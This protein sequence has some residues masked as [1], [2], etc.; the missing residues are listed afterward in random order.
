MIE[1]CKDPYQNS[2]QVL[3]A[4]SS[5]PWLTRSTRAE[6]WIKEIA[7][8]IVT[9]P[10]WAER[11]PNFFTD[12]L[13]TLQKEDIIGRSPLLSV[14]EA[15][16][17]IPAEQRGEHY[18]DNVHAVIGIIADRVTANSQITFANEEDQKLH[19]LHY[20]GDLHG[21][22][23]IAV[24]SKLGSPYHELAEVLLEK[25]PQKKTPE[26]LP[27]KKA[28]V[29][30]SNPK[31]P[32]KLKRL[33][34]PTSH[35]NLLK[36]PARKWPEPQKNYPSNTVPNISKKTQDFLQRFPRSFPELTHQAKMKKL[37]SFS[38][39]ASKLVDDASWYDIAAIA[40]R[41]KTHRFAADQFFKKAEP[42]LANSCREMCERKSEETL[43][44]KSAMAEVYTVMSNFYS[45]TPELHQQ[46]YDAYMAGFFDHDQVMLERLVISLAYSLADADF[47][48]V[49]DRMLNYL[50]DAEP[51]MPKFVAAGAIRGMPLGSSWEYVALDES[52][53]IATPNLLSQTS[54]EGG[55]FKALQN[56]QGDH[57]SIHPEYDI[58]GFRVDF[59]IQAKN[60]DRYVIEFDGMQFHY[61]NHL[62]ENGMLWE[63]EVREC[64]IDQVLGMP[65][66]RIPS[67]DWP[68]DLKERNEYLLN[69]L[70]KKAPTLFQE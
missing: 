16:G 4:Q 20:L 49:W 9:D 67:I 27:L 48:K 15:L 13:S 3:G 66:I 32:K 19:A 46:M 10:S 61:I 56:I 18:A 52:V 47:K 55:V 14:L 37:A 5:E 33:T 31:Q 6:T 38:H 22:K 54:Y 58:Q 24:L 59:M 23:F 8:V 29:P 44:D 42:R 26:K 41:F 69:L 28:P 40:N 17:T 43:Y 68:S 65:V 70:R 50:G 11:H 53:F 30:A 57:F 25:L 64:Y 45:S 60:G 2:R 1:G 63:E 7:A 12:D 35:E 21:R 39:R 34:P 62:Y 51:S 36:R